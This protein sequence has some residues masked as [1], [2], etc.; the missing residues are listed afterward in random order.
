MGTRDAKIG[1]FLLFVSVLLC[2][3]AIRLGIGQPHNPGSG[4]FPLLAGLIIGVLSLLLILS[5]TRVK[6]NHDSDR[7]PWMT[8]RAAFI[9]CALLAFGF[10]V[11]KVG[12]FV[13]TFFA[14]LLM[15]RMTSTKKWPYLFFV[16]ILTCLGVFFIFN[17]LLEVRLPLGILRPGGP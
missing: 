12:F 6:P 7:A 14:T 9:V 11:E 5:S 2:Y 8:G 1:I 15:L 10:L 13:C 16:A 17:V 4:F 3:G